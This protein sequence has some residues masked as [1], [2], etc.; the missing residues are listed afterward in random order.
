M[1]FFKFILLVLIV[2]NNVFA[3]D[4]SSYR[5]DDEDGLPS[6]E[7]YQVIQDDFGFIWIA[8]DAGLYRYDGFKFKNYTSSIQN[9]RSVSNLKKDHFGAIWCQNFTG[10]VFRIEKDSMR[11][12]YDGSKLNSQFP[13][14]TIDLDN[15][16]WI[17]T[18]KGISIYNYSAK[19]VKKISNFNFSTKVTGWMTIQVV[20]KDVIAVSN[21]GEFFKINCRSKKIIQLAVKGNIGSRHLLF[22]SNNQLILFSEK[23]PKREYTV[24]RL[25]NNSIQPE[26]TEQP[27]VASGTHY[28]Y[29]TIGENNFM[30]TSDG[31]LMCSKSKSFSTSRKHFLKGL[32]VSD[33]FEDC[34]GSLWVSTLQDG[35]IVVPNKDILV[36]NSSNSKLTDRNLYQLFSTNEELLVGT[37]SGEIFNLSKQNNQLSAFQQNNE[38]KFRAIRKII[39]HKNTF[40]IACGPLRV[41]GRPELNE[42]ASLNNIRDMLV[43]N[44]LLYFITP[45]R[46]GYI[47]LKS[48]T[49]KIKI[50]RKIGGKKLACDKRSNQVFIAFNDGLFRWDGKKIVS[51]KYKNKAVFATDLLFE[52]NRLWVGTM[53]EGVLFKQANQFKHLDPIIGNNVKSIFYENGNLWVATENGLNKYAIKKHSVNLL[54]R[55]DGLDL[56]EINDIEHFGNSLYLA[57]I[58]GLVSFPLSIRFEN[59]VPPTIKLTGVKVQNDFQ[60]ITKQVNLDANQ[61]G[62]GI[63]FSSTALRSRGDFS[64]EYRI[65]NYNSSWKRQAATAPFVSITYLPAGDYTFEIR[66]VNEDGIYSKKIARLKIH[67]EAPYYEKWWFYVLIALFAAMIVTALF[68][69]RINYLKRQSGIKNKLILSQL[70]AL[71][72]QMNPHFMYNTLSS[73]QDFIWKNDTKNS[74]YYL[75]RF[76]L[77]MRKVLDASDSEKISLSEEIEILS[78]YLEMEQLRFGDVFQYAITIDEEVDLDYIH[79]PAMII[80]PFVE[81][82]IK[83]GLLHKKGEKSLSIHFTQV[84]HNI[85]CR[86]ED[87][88][89]G[90]LKAEEIKKRQAREHK[91]F[92]TT[93]TQKRIELLSLYNDNAFKVD[94]VDLYK[95]NLPTGTQVNLVLPF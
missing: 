35:I 39:V 69:V 63:Y 27:I 59:K 24:S 93:A 90:R 62:L 82:A 70:T 14:Y 64:Y 1:K 57:T 60:R 51:L 91:S 78:L 81:N 9:S 76:S 19:C 34:E 12:F 71:K 55:A 36:Y 83:H 58:K 85:H 28:F 86:I 47:D 5:I 94:I 52:N 87:N 41:I 61:K 37:Y 4:F 73:I 33:V 54:N 38:A 46:M 15:N 32:K 26:F 8:C 6:N 30:G 88:G 21:S 20:G 18:N 17:T 80:Q 25:K 77:L 44:E 74:N 89:I 11:L 23:N 40:Y 3:Q 13:A 79:I 29:K 22:N 75:S 2:Q 42:L 65:L 50:L 48:T 68:L 72:A 53:T 67:V 45:D 43:L 95:E 66:S 56:I 92:A 10:Q 16:I 84:E 49:P 7:V 31:L